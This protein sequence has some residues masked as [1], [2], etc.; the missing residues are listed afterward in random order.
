MKRKA[1]K[2]ML[3]EWD[4]RSPG[5]KEIIFKSIKNIAPSH[6]LD[7]ELFDFEN[8]TIKVNKSAVE[9]EDLVP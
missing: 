8:Y 2:D 3:S 4:K 7:K 9:V 1:V 6:M 5:R